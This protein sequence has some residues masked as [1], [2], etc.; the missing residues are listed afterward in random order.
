[1]NYGYGLTPEY[2]N[3]P[4]CF[5]L[6]GKRYLYFGDGG[7]LTNDNNNSWLSSV[8]EPFAT[9]H[10]FA[11]DPEY[12]DYTPRMRPNATGSGSGAGGIYTNVV[13]SFFFANIIAWAVE[14]AQ[15][16]GINAK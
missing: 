13:N 1:I 9:S 10:D 8:R 15:Y 2:Q 7:F 4:T 5:R 11:G 12:N 6:V 14:E 3:E 16:Y